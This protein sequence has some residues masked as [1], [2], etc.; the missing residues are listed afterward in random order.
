MEK[1]W[2]KIATIFIITALIFVTNAHAGN[3]LKHSVIKIFTVSKKYDYDNPWQLRGQLKGTG[4]GCIISGNRILTSAHVVADNSFLQVKKA[5]EARKY[6]ARVA[7]IS[8]ESDLAILEVRDKNFFL[9]AK[10]VPLGT[11][12]QVRDKVAV[13]G[14]PTGGD[15]LSITE[16]VVSRIEQRRYAHSNANLLTCQIDAAINPGNSGG[17]VILHNRIIGVAFQSSTQG[18]NLGY[19]VP[20][21]V[22]KHFLKDI[23]DG[24]YRGFPSMGIF[25]QKMESPELRK[26]FKL[27]KPL[28]GVRV[29]EILLESPARGILK[30]DDILLKIDGVS[31]AN[32]GSVEFRPGERTALNYIVQKKYINDRVSLEVLREGRRLSLKLRLSLPMNSTR[33]VPFEQYDEPPTYYI[34]GGLVFVPLTQNYLQTWGRQWYFSAPAKLMNYYLNG[35]RTEEKKEVVLLSKVLADEINLGYHNLENLVIVKVNGRDIHD[36]K[37]LVKAFRENK[38]KYNVIVDDM[39]RKII[40]NRKKAEKLGGQ[41]LARYRITRDSSFNLVP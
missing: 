36:M 32:D 30:K 34:N 19:M 3:E 14:F 29:A 20:V 25:F 1:I 26:F 11:L 4:S 10:P 35:F 23:M 18:E 39:N 2:K 5:G 40:I 7:A 8:H 33:L 24:N 12:P 6:I 21:P 16:G 41:I 37:S 31:I 13:Y 17:P 38:K 9:N 27:K 28:S 22:I 15:E